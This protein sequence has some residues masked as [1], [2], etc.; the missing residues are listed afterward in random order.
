MASPIDS[1]KKA[2]IPPFQGTYG[3]IDPQQTCSQWPLYVKWNASIPYE[4]DVKLTGMGCFIPSCQIHIYGWAL[5]AK[6][7]FRALI[8]TTQMITAVQQQVSRYVSYKPLELK[9]RNQ[10]QEGHSMEEVIN[11]DNEIKK[12]RIEW[13]AIVSN[14]FCRLLH[15][16]VQ[17]Q[18]SINTIGINQGLSNRSQILLVCIAKDHIVGLEAEIRTLK[19]EF[20]CAPCWISFINSPII[21]IK[22]IQW[23]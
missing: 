10:S 16:V 2:Y 9:L 6:Q 11:E 12:L 7:F 5:H 4:T 1:D 22:L 3:D 21:C 13:F 17:N 14:V 8:T 23:L 18:R 19:T 15:R 20:L